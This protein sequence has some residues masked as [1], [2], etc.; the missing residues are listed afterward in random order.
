[1][2]KDILL[3][4]TN[5]LLITGGDF[6][7]EESEMQEVGLILQ[8]NQGE[9]KA[10]PLTGANLVREVR[11]STNNLRKERTMRIQMKLDGKDYDKIRKQIKEQYNN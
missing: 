6:V 2:A 9:W 7:I 10:E 5:D 4:D 3:D 11:G 1:M 8:T